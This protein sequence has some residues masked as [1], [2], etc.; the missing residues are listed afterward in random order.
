MI[1]SPVSFVFEADARN[2]GRARAA[3]RE[4]MS[5]AGAYLHLDAALLVVSELV[6]NAFVHTGTG[7]S[8]SVWCSPEGTRIEVE[9]G[10]SHLPVRRHFATTAGTGRGLH[11]VE[12]LSDRWGAELRTSGKAVWFELGT[13]AAALMDAGSTS[14]DQPPPGAHGTAHH[15]VTLRAAPV[16]MHWAW[17]EHASSLLRE[18][19]LHVLDHDDT[20]MDRH[21]SASEALRLLEEQFPVPVLSDD[22]DALMVDALEPAVTA[23]EVLLRVPASSVDH[24]V[25]LDDLLGRA[26]REARAGHF[27]GPPTQPEI[28]EM[29]VWLCTEVAR[30][31][32]GDKTATPWVARTDVRATLAD[33]V[34]LRETYADLATTDDALLATDEASIIVAASP[35]AVQLL[36]Y[37]DADELL[38]RRILVVVPMRFHQAHIAGTT[39]NA[40]NGRDNLLGVQLEVPMVR[41][42]GSEVSVSIEVC[43]ERL[44]GERHVF[45]ARFSR[46]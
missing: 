6:T 23:D 27:L 3:V 19:L 43:P 38:G 31:A 37:D 29:R 4:V 24:F 44:D 20:I 9:D 32:G 25:I 12:E 8:V 14:A 2:V 46:A 36:G 22:A 42:D 39:L 34:L 18:Y 26:T 28:E 16:L 15:L 33:Q 45:V 11:L 35:L 1:E 5:G 41:K 40:T 17:Q 13:L 7:V 10:G 30:Q 21:A